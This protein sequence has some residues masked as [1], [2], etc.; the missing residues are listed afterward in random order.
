MCFI[1]I[2]DFH[3]ISSE[4]DRRISQYIFDGCDHITNGLNLDGFDGEN[5]ICFVHS[6]IFGKYVFKRALFLY[7]YSLK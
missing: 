2:D 1:E 4:S 3:A 5:I 7:V 6:K